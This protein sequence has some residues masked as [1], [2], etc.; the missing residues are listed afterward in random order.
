MAKPLRVVVTPDGD[1]EL[2]PVKSDGGETPH[3]TTQKLPSQLA[4]DY[5]DEMCNETFPKMPPPNKNAPSRTAA[6][7]E[8]LPHGGGTSKHPTSRTPASRRVLKQ[9]KRALRYGE[10]IPGEDDGGHGE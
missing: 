7:E 6:E 10:L 4:A 5:E 9:G 3:K 1:I 2:N 8:E